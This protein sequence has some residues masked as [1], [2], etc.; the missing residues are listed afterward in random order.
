M[1]KKIPASI[2]EVIQ[3]DS[4]TTDMAEKATTDVVYKNRASVKKKV[5]EKTGKGAKFREKFDSSSEEKLESSEQK[6]V[7]ELVT[8]KGLSV[9]MCDGEEVVRN[10]IIIIIILKL[11]SLIFSVFFIR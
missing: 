11:Y 6:T 10:C 3:T 4:T 7:V 1:C 8:G 5:K 9:P 2:E